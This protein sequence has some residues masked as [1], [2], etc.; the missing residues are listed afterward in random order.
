[1]LI[2]PGLILG[3]FCYIQTDKNEHKRTDSLLCGRIT[4]LWIMETKIWKL[5]V[6]CI[7]YHSFPYSLSPAVRVLQVSINVLYLPRPSIR[8]HSNDNY[9]R[10]RLYNTGYPF[11]RVF[12]PIVMATI[13]VPVLVKGENRS[14]ATKRCTRS[15]WIRSSA[16]HRLS[17]RRRGWDGW[18]GGNIGSTW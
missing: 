8:L 12:G 1:M 4:S 3:T 10:I 15:T 7:C 18:S 14:V 5:T 6:C 2:Q 16:T 13:P 11:G 17:S 9:D